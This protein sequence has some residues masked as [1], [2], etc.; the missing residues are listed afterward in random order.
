VGQALDATKT[1]LERVRANL[2][3]V[4]GR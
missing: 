4:A 1:H 2:L 3:G